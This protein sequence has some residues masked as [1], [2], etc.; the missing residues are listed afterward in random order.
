MSRA[1]SR[2]RG[3]AGGRTRPDPLIVAAALNRLI[4][5]DE[6]GISEYLPRMGAEPFFLV[7]ATGLGKTVVVPVHVW[8]EQCARAEP[9]IIPTT[10]IVEPR[11]LIAEDQ[12]RYM[13]STMRR[14]MRVVGAA[15]PAPLFG[16]VT[17]SG[18]FNASAPIKF[19]TT[20]VF[21]IKAL[22][23]DFTP[24]VDR[25]VIDEAHETIAQNA[26][27]ELA[28]AVARRD[29]I[30][31]DYMSATV[32]TASIPELL[33][34]APEN[35]IVATKKRYPIFTVNAAKSLSECLVEIVDD[36]LVRQNLNSR[37]LPPVNYPGRDQILADLFDG[38]ARSHALLV[39]LNTVSSSRSDFAMARRVLDGANPLV[40][41]KP[42]DVLELSSRQTGSELGMQEFE[43]RRG[44]IESAHRPYIVLATSV[45]EMGVTIPAL[46]FVVTMDSGFRS[47]T[48]GDRSVP[49]IV[50]L[51]FN[52][53][54]QRLGRVGRRRAGVGI[55]TREVGAAYTE[56]DVEQL[57]SDLLDY[58]PVRTP[59]ADA[60]LDSL[61]LYT[62]AEGWSEP[63]QVA[64]GL[65]SLALPSEAQLLTVGRL[66]DLVSERRILTSL[67][68]S[69]GLGLSPLGKAAASWIGTGWLQYAFEVERAWMM[70]AP[71]EEVMFW[72]VSLAIAD[73]DLSGLLINNATVDELNARGTL[74]AAG[75]KF[76][77]NLHAPLGRYD[78]VR[79]FYNTY[80]SHLVGDRGLGTLRQL[81][82]TTLARDCADLDLS[83]S[84]LKGAMEAVSSA[85][86]LF[87][88]R[89]RKDQRSIAELVGPLPALTGQ[90]RTRLIR[91][92]H[93]IAGQVEL[94]IGAVP[95]GHP[96]S[97]AW[98]LTDGTAIAT[99]GS[100]VPD[101]VEGRTFTA[102]LRLRREADPNGFWLDVADHWVR[103][104]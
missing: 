90:N 95:G 43:R 84:R 88:K 68:A 39:A 26:D 70:G 91:R 45:I 29:G 66:K 104:A 60:R 65:Q 12:A 41:G 2:Q 4:E 92:A 3:G 81:A 21:T 51:P 75:I 7:A 58:E 24:G 13:E 55:I 32:D 98:M 96:D 40:S 19:V 52:S 97:R 42:I 67:G 53:L 28:L 16:S 102:R 89:H 54:K 93:E 30:H 37:F 86:D 82:D 57:N 73:L 9:G 50:P 99:A 61:A 15:N 11:V 64:A 56:Y 23:H 20:G 25:I 85:R 35:V 34:I 31:I 59:L 1:G 48:V 8:L 101:F 69:D 46:D 6:L 83:M 17:S 94:A 80:A 36:L 33:R 22:S 76:V 103:T 27:V 5:E 63:A 74:S 18:P 72:L 49:E 44:E 14:L 100:A 47:I 10:W 87:L 71:T 79:S 38:P 77:D 78:L 62:L